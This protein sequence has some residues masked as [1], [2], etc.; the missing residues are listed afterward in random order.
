MLVLLGVILAAAAAFLVARPILLS[1]DSSSSTSPA[2]VATTPSTPASSPAPVKPATTPAKP[3]VVLLPGLPARV[4]GKLQHSNVVVV[5]VYS[6]TA[7]GDRSAVVAARKGAKDA[8][9]A[10]AALN[11]LDEPTA[12]Q[13][14]PWLGVVSSPV[15]LVVRRP[16]NIV[17][18]F[19]KHVDEKVVAQAALNARPG[20]PA[21]HAASK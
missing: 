9:V 10:F 5:S 13:L 21:K 3:A 18:R 6:A 14:E 11:V 20:G 1:D 2:P 12:L 19:D 4:A 15:V 16:G 17:L 8:G 7:A